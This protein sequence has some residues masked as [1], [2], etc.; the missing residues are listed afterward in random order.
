MGSSEE[1]YTKNIIDRLQKLEERTS[2]IAANVASIAAI[3]KTMN[4]H[5]ERI[6]EIE[7]N[8]KN[9]AIVINAVKWVTISIVGSAITVIIVSIADYIMGK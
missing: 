1:E 9:N 6:R 8:N 3:I 2:D 4:S 7:L 5:E